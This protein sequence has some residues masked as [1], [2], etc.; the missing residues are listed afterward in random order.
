MSV[1]QQPEKRRTPRVQPYVVPC[2]MELPNG[3][4]LSGYVTDLSPLGAQVSCDGPPPAAG[5]R[6]ALEVR[7]R[8]GTAW[9]VLKAEVKWTRPPARAGA[10]PTCG[11]TFVEVAAADRAL[12][13]GALEDFRRRVAQLGQGQR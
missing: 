10:D 9:P 13:E 6:V 4:R 11:L 5:I 7:L 12:L 2:R 1:S 8:R 3:R